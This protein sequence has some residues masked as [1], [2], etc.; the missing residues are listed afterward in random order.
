MVN[1][2]FMGIKMNQPSLIAN[3]YVYGKMAGDGSPVAVKV[4]MLCTIVTKSGFHTGSD[5]SSPPL[6]L[7]DLFHCKIYN[8]LTNLLSIPKNLGTIDACADSVYQAVF[9]N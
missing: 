9:L 3:V 5:I 8:I 1:H 6:P 4:C 2:Y 7:S